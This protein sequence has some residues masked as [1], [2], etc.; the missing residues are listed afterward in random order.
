MEVLLNPCQTVLLEARVSHDPLDGMYESSLGAQR[1][2][3]VLSRLLSHATDESRVV[4]LVRTHGIALFAGDACPDV[5]VVRDVL[6]YALHRPQD[7]RP[8]GELR[9]VGG[10]WAHGGALAALHAIEGAGVLYELLH[11][12]D[13]LFF[14]GLFPAFLLAELY[15]AKC[16]HLLDELVDRLCEL[17]SLGRIYPFGPESPR[18][19]AHDVEQLLQ[20][21]DP[22]LR[23][24]VARDVMAVVH[25]AADDD[26]TVRPALEGVH[27]DAGFDAPAA[28][29]ADDLNVRR[30]LDLVDPR[31]VG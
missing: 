15:G 20:R 4:H 8:R 14:R 24:L 11:L 17:R 16:P 18:V 7:D 5:P 13:R 29:D 23:L 31:E 2:R 12:G 9:V 22:L 19:E 26:H 1:R 6:H 3:A 10:D 27:D 28:H 30:I 25:Q 21:L